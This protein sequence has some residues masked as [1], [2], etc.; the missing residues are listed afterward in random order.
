MGKSL[1][2]AMTDTSRTPT[3]KEQSAVLEMQNELSSSPSVVE[4]IRHPCNSRECAYYRTHNTMERDS[5]ATT[6]TERQFEKTQSCPIT[7]QQKKKRPLFYDCARN[8]LF[9]TT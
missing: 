6:M 9:D 7:E 5:S 4:E 2:T 1:T 3:S 8:E